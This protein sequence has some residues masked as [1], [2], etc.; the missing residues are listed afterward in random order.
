M[1]VTGFRVG[2]EDFRW[3]SL[4]PELVEELPGDPGIDSNAPTGV[5][6]VR[7]FLVLYRCA[8]KVVRGGK[9]GEVTVPSMGRTGEA[10]LDAEQCISKPR[11]RRAHSGVVLGLTSPGRRG[12]AGRYQRGARKRCE[13]MDGRRG[14]GK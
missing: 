1:G 12:R 9:L 7:L 2:G 6:T 11:R 14:T 13:G 8:F 4:V 3:R 10:A 5:G